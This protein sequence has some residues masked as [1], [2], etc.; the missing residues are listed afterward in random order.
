MGQTSTSQGGWEREALERGLKSLAEAIRRRPE[1]YAAQADL[2]A[3]FFLATH[4]DKWY[5]TPVTG[6]ILAPGTMAELQ[7][8]GVDPH[9]I[10]ELHRDGLLQV[11]ESRRKMSVVVSPATFDAL[12]EA[13]T[14]AG[15]ASP[16]PPR[17]ERERIIQEALAAWPLPPAPA[18]HGYVPGRLQA[19]HAAQAAPQ[20]AP[21]D[22][23]QL[24]ERLNELERRVAD[25][26]RRLDDLRRCLSQCLASS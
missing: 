13:F 16:L 24:V 1:Y 2:L 6:E 9:F 15:V 18:P 21:Q 20:P 25:L 5:R 23:G 8:A 22:L 19:E 26:G 4:R 3:R 11:L 12:E 14:R 10:D 17:E 7:S